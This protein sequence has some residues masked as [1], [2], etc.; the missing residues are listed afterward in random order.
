[1]ACETLLLAGFT[2]EAIGILARTF[3]TG[4]G[5]A[6][7]G[8]THGHKNPPHRSRRISASSDCANVFI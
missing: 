8:L 1:M 4:M 3:G 7:A 5:F 2:E 6:G